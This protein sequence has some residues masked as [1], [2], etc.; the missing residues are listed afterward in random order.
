MFAPLAPVAIAFLA[1]IGIEFAVKSVA[2][3][4]IAVRHVQ[5]SLV[6]LISCPQR[7]RQLNELRRGS[8]ARGGAL[9]SGSAQLKVRSTRLLR[10]VNRKLDR[11]EEARLI[12]GELQLA[13]VKVG[14]GLDE[15]EPEP[16]TLVGAAGRQPAR[17]RP[18]HR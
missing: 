10:G 2:V 11:V 13:V 4:K 6:R 7:T 3:S 14:D 18:G 8:D 17:T 15:R 12:V 9:A 1:T 5:S 16:R